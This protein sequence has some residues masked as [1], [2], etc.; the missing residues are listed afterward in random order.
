M[1]IEAAL[2]IK[3]T[4]TELEALVKRVA[5]L[6]KQIEW[7]KKSVERKPGRPRKTE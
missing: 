4:A 1:S 7:L 6:E 3:Q 2:K 5:E